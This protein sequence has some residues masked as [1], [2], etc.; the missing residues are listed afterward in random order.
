MKCSTWQG[1][2]NTS[3]VSGARQ[4]SFF[5]YLHRLSWLECESM[6]IFGVSKQP[7]ALRMPVSG[8]TTRSTYLVITKVVLRS[9]RPAR[10]KYLFDSDLS[11]RAHSASP[12]DISNMSG[13]RMISSWAAC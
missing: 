8:P 1:W 5:Q 11:I 13:F 2:Q 7:A 12:T 4:K 10:G 9:H 6:V 3:F